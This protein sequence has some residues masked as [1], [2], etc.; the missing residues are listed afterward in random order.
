MLKRDVRVKVNAEQAEQILALARLNGFEISNTT[1]SE[2]GYMFVYA[3]S[4]AV[5]YRTE[6]QFNRYAK[7]MQEMQAK[8]VIELL[9]D[10][11][12]VLPQCYREHMTASEVD[13]Y[14]RSAKA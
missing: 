7:K 3:S 4:K 6:Q 13:E 14:L 5:G 8:E 10:D 9:T 11:E 1:E 2:F 12:Y